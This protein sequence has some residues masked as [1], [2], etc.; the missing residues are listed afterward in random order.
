L[1]RKNTQP[2]SRSKKSRNVVFFCGLTA[3][4]F[5]TKEDE[6]VNARR[7]RKPQELMNRTANRKMAQE[8]A[9]GQTVCSFINAMLL[10]E[11]RSACSQCYP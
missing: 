4:T 2:A 3:K 8:V 11:M 9:A 10:V 1:R 7:R 6:S 5:K